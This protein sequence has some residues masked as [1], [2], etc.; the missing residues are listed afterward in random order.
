VKVFEGAMKVLRM[1]APSESRPVADV[2]AGVGTTGVAA[3][4]VLLARVAGILSRRRCLH[5]EFGTRA[6]ART[7]LQ[8]MCNEI[9]SDI[10]I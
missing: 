7:S 5:K 4:K 10:T 8:T 6:R 2:G 3:M 1:R 9:R